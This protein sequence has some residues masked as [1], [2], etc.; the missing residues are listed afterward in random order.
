[1]PNGLEETIAATGFAKAL[2]TLRPEAAAASADTLGKELGVYF[3]PIDES[4][5]RD[6]A[7]SASRASPSRS[8]SFRPTHTP[9]LRVF[10]RLGLAIGLVRQDQAAALRNDARVEKVELAPELSLI[11]PVASSLAK[12]APGTTWGIERLDTTARA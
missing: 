2:V 12:S 4:Q 8:K 6:L 9:K 10:P 3:D 11:R 5:G 7:A 1:M